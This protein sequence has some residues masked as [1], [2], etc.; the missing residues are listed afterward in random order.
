MEQ[1]QPIR[2]VLVAGV[3]GVGGYFGGRLAL[4]AAASGGGVGIS[5]LAR[6]AHLEAIRG[7][8]LSLH[9]QG[10]ELSC[11]P[12]LATD[13]PREVPPPDLC[14]LC[15]KGYDLPAVLES[16]A[17]RL[18]DSSVILPL[19]NGV[20]IHERVVRVCG[21]TIVLPACA[22]VSAN[23]QS[24]GIVVQRGQEGTILLGPDPRK[25]EPY[26]H[27]GTR[28]PSGDGRAAALRGLLSEAG[29]AHTWSPDPRAGI[30]QKYLFIA[31]FGIVTAWSRKSMGEVL[32]D[33][34]LTALVR[35]IMGEI[36]AL[37][38]AR[39]VPLPEGAVGQALAKARS[40]PGE[41]RTS[42]QR[43]VEAG[44]RNEGELFGGT[45]QRLGREL[46]VQV[47]VASR[48][49]GEIPETR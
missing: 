45:I 20:D 8:G 22:Y 6:G 48:L 30:W 17:P 47:P 39:Q 46:G 33:Q 38:R 4:A 44:G 36:A 41:T 1:E 2:H 25:P 43:D 26:S 28:P 31:S 18:R 29:I 16:L 23:I 37:A 34:E 15:V 40:F 12:D 42:Y 49:H 7:R 11:R 5:F 14:L 21:H 9:T 32:A 27:P 19:L 24:P 35:A 3:G 10:G 13:D